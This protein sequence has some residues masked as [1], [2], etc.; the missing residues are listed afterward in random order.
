MSKE[1]ANYIDFVNTV[2]AI[3]EH[4]S[5]Y[6]AQQVR[7]EVKL[8]RTEDIIEQKCKVVT[9]ATIDEAEEGILPS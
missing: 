7:C 3:A 8:Q 1:C 4:V 2:N 6:T 5:A 9:F